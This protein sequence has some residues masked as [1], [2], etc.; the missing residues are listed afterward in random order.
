MSTAGE[1]TLHI[2]DSAAKRIAALQAKES[3]PGLMLRVTVEGGGCS[4]FQYKFDLDD[5]VNEDDITFERNGIR[6][7]TDDASL[8]L[9]NDAELDFI[10]ELAGSYFKVENPN[11]SSSCGCGTSF[12][13]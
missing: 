4:G 13:V 7:V 2:S 9:L 1:R 6:V 5:K 12:S 11:A 8:N 10:D 3:K